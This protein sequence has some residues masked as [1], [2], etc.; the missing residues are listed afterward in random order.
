MLCADRK[1][2]YYLKLKFVTVTFKGCFLPAG[3]D[4]PGRFSSFY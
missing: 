2:V 4:P 3:W 1:K